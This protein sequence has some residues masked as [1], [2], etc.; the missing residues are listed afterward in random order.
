MKL[1]RKI[2]ALVSLFTSP[3]LSIIKLFTLTTLICLTLS[4]GSFGKVS[5][6]KHKQSGKQMVWKKINYGQMKEKEKLQLINE[7]NI[8]RELKHENIVRYHDKIIDRKNLTIYIIMEYCPGGD[9]GQLIKKCKNSNMYI[10]EEFI[11]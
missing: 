2:L 8:L 3:S 1:L 7:V 11:W 4:L 6:V 5:L 9:L 10:P